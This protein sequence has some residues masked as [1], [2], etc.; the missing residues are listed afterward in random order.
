MVSPTSS[1]RRLAPL[2]KTR[3]GAAPR[4]SEIFLDALGSRVRQ[5]RHQAVA[6]HVFGGRFQ[7][8]AVGR[9]RHGL[10]NDA[11][12]LVAFFF[13]EIERRQLVRPRRGSL[14]PGPDSLP[15]FAH[16]AVAATGCGAI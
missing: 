14:E 7:R 6:P 13:G 1:P 9:Q 2:P 4:A 3:R 10:L 12:Q 5:V 8:D 11:S 16:C 15:F